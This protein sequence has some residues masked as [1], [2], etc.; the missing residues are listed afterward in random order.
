MCPLSSTGRITKLTKFDNPKDNVYHKHITTGPSAWLSKE[1]CKENKLKYYVIE[2]S[3]FLIRK[4]VKTTSTSIV[5]LWEL[6]LGDF[7]KKAPSVSI[8]STWQTPPLGF[9]HPIRLLVVTEAIRE[10]APL[11]PAKCS[12][13][14]ISGYDNAASEA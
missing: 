6:K 7:Y 11:C 14:Q 4:R 1:A 10:P 5:L 13:L 3:I 8:T 12:H 2:S 9:T